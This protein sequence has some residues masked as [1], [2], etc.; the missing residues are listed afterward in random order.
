MNNSENNENILNNPINDNAQE[1][2]MSPVPEVTTIVEPIPVIQ[3]VPVLEPTVEQVEVAS[4]AVE[5]APVEEIPASPIVETAPVVPEIQV[6]EQPVSSENTEIPVI[7]PIPVVEETISVAT[8]TPSIPEIQVMEQPI[9]SEI[10]VIEPTSVM[11]SVPTTDSMPTIEP[12][13]VVEST[14]VVEQPVS[15][16]EP[17]VS[18]ETPITPTVETTPVVE[19][20]PTIEPVPIVESAPVVEQPVSPSEASVSVETPV[21]PTVE[22]TPV[23]EPVPTIEPTQTP[24]ESQPTTTPA[25][26]NVE[27]TATPVS[28][29][30]NEAPA[31]KS[32]PIAIVVLVVA[33]IVLVVFGIN[34]LG[35]FS[36]DKTPSGTEGGN[37]TEQTGTLLEN[38]DI[39][40]YMCMGQECT[41]NINGTDESSIFYYKGNNKELFDELSDYKDDIKVNIYYKDEKGKKIITSYEIFLKESNENISSIKNINELRE[42]LGLYALG[43]QTDEL[44]LKEIG[45]PGFGFSNDESYTYV[46]YEFENN[47]GKVFE[48]KYIFKDGESQDDLALEIDKKYNVTFEV[49]EGTF[50]IEYNIKSINQ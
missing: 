37:D 22:A 48:M 21:T 25:T 31:K 32:S 41:Y 34:K 2:V 33:L 6:M 15:P 30:S 43:T 42:K 7:E 39:S 40:G 36:K 45:T 1:P 14:P 44:T 12:V 38:I 46:D 28:Q 27:P 29:S 5:V 4:P 20:V 3:P 9:N 11:E 35:I 23:V 49:V 18:V 8:E 50:H 47:S 17:S 19:P 26:P 13:S 24:T 16:A 10:P